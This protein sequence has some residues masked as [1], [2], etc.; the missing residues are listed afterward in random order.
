MDLNKKIAERRA[1]LQRDQA[2]EIERR[3]REAREQAELRQA[4]ERVIQELAEKK[5][6]QK[7]QTIEV[8]LREPKES[9]A[10][11]EL[12]Q[13]HSV[14]EADDCTD[15]NQRRVTEEVEKRVEKHIRK[16]AQ[17]RMTSNENA[18]FWTLVVGGIAGFFAA[19]WVGLGLLLVAGLYASKVI[20]RHEAKIKSEL[21]RETIF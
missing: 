6:R 1:E 19:W 11:V 20:D 14:G 3:R 9:I 15:Q 8:L 12:D 13:V 4:E 16:M 17:E 2:L 21:G 10:P 18:G 7:V 5:A